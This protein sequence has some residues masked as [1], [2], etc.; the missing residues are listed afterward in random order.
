MEGNFTYYK[1]I[2]FLVEIDR[3]ANEFTDFDTF[4]WSIDGGITFIEEYIK[5]DSE[6]PIPLMHG[7][8]VQFNDYEG[9][10]SH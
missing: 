10:R 9:L 8:S 1:P 5:I 7:L 3:L 6:N 4:R 2:S